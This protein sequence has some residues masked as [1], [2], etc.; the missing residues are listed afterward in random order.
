M[1]ASR[2]G[3]KRGWWLVIVMMAA[4][5]LLAISANGLV[6]PRLRAEAARPI[7][8]PFTP[9]Y[10][11]FDGDARPDCAELAGRSDEQSIRLTLSGSAPTQL[12]FHNDTRDRGR[13]L[14]GDI[15]HDNDYDLVWV[16]TTEPLLF[17]I[18]TG[19]GKGHFQAMPDDRP[20]R[21]GIGALLGLD[22]ET[23]ISTP[24]VARHAADAAA[25]SDGPVFESARVTP[26]P[27]FF[28]ADCH[29]A[30]YRDVAAV[31]LLPLTGRSPPLAL[32][33]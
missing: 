30:G 24:P 31:A 7:L 13:L 1:R 25:R 22:A 14:A 16:S 15:D 6:S 8:L 28:A 11:D 23:D 18:W 5:L 27:Q 4:P 2:N 32:S 17:R 9:L 29:Q 10:S 33:C 12:H 3:D 26:A 19:D 21:K 20:F